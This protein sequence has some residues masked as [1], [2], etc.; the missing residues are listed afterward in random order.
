M[1][2]V[3]S[4]KPGGGPVRSQFALWGHWAHGVPCQYWPYLGEAGSLT[5]FAPKPL[6]T[7]LMSLMLT[8]PSGTFG[9]GPVMSPLHETVTSPFIR[10]LSAVSVSPGTG[11]ARPCCPHDGVTS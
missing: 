11:S 5:R 3:P 9:V 1:F 10:V 2:I 4:G 7:R 6:A 8:V